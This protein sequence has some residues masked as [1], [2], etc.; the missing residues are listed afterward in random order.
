MFMAHS[1]DYLHVTGRHRIAEDGD[2]KRIQYH[3]YGGPE[4]MRLEEFEPA[5]PGRGDVLVRVKAAALNPMDIGIRRG[6]LKMV[7][8]RKFPRALGHDFA[9]IVEEVGDGVTQVRPGDEVIG[10][11]GIKTAGAFAEM[12]LVEEKSVVRKPRNLSWDEAAALPTPA[13]TAYL[14]LTKK[15]RLKAGQSVFVAGAL[16]AVGRSAVQL[17]MMMGASVGGSC[18]GTA[19]QEAHDLGL[20]PIVEFDFDASRYA[21][22]FD[23]VLDTSGQLPLASAKTMVKSG[24]HIVD[25]QPAPAKFVR[26]AL[27]GPYEVL[28]ANPDRAD[29][30]Q[31]VRAAEQGV[32]RI[33]IASVVPLD[34]AIPALAEYERRTGPKGGKLIITT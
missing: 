8:G 14:A 34:K 31:M 30:E 32:L 18:R 15:G 33:P 7:T 19:V 16:G 17:A 20:S 29:V 10:A 26:A 2:M 13:I 21:R 9:G 6:R 23:V 1:S 27:P 5:R 22:R 3:E 28:V 24:G 12:V 11:A 4:V 25:I